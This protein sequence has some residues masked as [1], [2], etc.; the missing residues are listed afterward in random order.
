MNYVS[1]NL[2]KNVK[3]FVFWKLSLFWIFTLTT[4]SIHSYSLWRYLELSRG[5][6]VRVWPPIQFVVFGQYCSSLSAIISI[7]KRDNRLLHG[8]FG[9]LKQFS[10][11]INSSIFYLNAEFWPT[12]MSFLKKCFH[13]LWCHHDV[14][15]LN[16][17][18]DF[19]IL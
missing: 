4:D 17:G 1:P 16:F 8:C 14:T 9:K 10:I 3:F 12:N 6:N 11:C 5:R 19:Y 15:T 7:I 13:S 2:A 18:V